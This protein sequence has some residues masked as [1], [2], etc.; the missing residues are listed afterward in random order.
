MS[1][2]G[3]RRGQ[4]RRRRAVRAACVPPPAAAKG[5]GSA[6]LGK[7]GNVSLFFFFSLLFSFFF[8]FA[9]FFFLFFL[10]LLF[11]SSFFFP[12]FFSLTL[13]QIWQ[14][15][16]SR[17]W[18]THAKSN[19]SL[20]LP[21]RPCSGNAPLPA[22]SSRNLARLKIPARPYGAGC[23]RGDLP[24]GPWTLCPEKAALGCG[25]RKWEF[26]RSFTCRCRG[27]TSLVVVD[28]P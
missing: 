12:F 21:C 11:N 3:W 18:R 1:S 19:P 7:T 25:K 2:A 16:A 10:F 14:D 4:C 22:R 20:A 8:F 27:C 13:G 24:R 9:F 23:G 6:T 17:V 5:L 26:A 28:E 15:P